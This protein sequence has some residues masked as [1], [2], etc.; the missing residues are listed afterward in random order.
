MLRR[1]AGVTLTGGPAALQALSGAGGKVKKAFQTCRA[2][3]PQGVP[4]ATG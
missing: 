2:L 3:L 4:T 1:S